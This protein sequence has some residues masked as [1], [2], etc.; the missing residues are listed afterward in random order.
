MV[1]REDNNDEHDVDGVS[2][3]P[4]INKQYYEHERGDR[5]DKKTHK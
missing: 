3:Y 2:M 5:R 1:M 4:H